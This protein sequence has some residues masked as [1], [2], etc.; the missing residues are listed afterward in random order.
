M[1]TFATFGRK[2]LSFP[3]ENPF[4]YLPIIPITQDTPLT[5]PPLTPSRIILSQQLCQQK[6][7]VQTGL[8]NL[9]IPVLVWVISVARAMVANIDNLQHAF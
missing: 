3:R 1:R 9:R 2:L 8:R 4:R 7:E 6:I 5:L